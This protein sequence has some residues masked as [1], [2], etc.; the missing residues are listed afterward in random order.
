MVKIVAERISQNSSYAS[1]VADNIGRYTLIRENEPSNVFRRPSIP[2]NSLQ[3]GEDTPASPFPSAST[4]HGK[5]Q[6]PVISHCLIGV[7]EDARGCFRRLKK[8]GASSI[9]KP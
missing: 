9:Y 7:E 4:Q 2:T 1:G 3:P 6:L 5:Q 8:G